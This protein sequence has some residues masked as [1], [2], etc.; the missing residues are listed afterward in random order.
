M[1]SRAESPRSI[2]SARTTL[3]ALLTTRPLTPLGGSEAMGRLFLLSECLRDLL[4][5]AIWFMAGANRE[6]A[7]KGVD[8]FFIDMRADIKQ[9]AD[10]KI[11][12]GR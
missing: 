10:G 2:A 11:D 6:Q 5:E 12:I 1:T 4:G 9:R 3:I 7:L 8:A